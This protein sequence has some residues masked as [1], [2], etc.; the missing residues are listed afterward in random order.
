MYLGDGAKAPFQSCDESYS[1]NQ[2]TNASIHQQKLY[3]AWAR[4]ACTFQQECVSDFY[5]YWSLEETA[6]I[7]AWIMVLHTSVD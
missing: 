6:A 1:V 3:S 5:T 4:I 7:I 2:G